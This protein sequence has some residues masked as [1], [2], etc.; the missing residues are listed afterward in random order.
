MQTLRWM[1]YNLHW[2]PLPLAPATSLKQQPEAIMGPD[3]TKLGSWRLEDG[4][5]SS[6]G[7]FQWACASDDDDAI[8]F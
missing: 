7:L 3:S 2:V 4:I 5:Q 1:G 6:A 8:P